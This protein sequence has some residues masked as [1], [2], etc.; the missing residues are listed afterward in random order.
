MLLYIPP[1]SIHRCD[2]IQA[3]IRLKY[4]TRMNQGPIQ[5]T[6]LKIFIKCATQ[7]YTARYAKILVAAQIEINGKDKKRPRLKGT[8]YFLHK[9]C[10][11]IDMLKNA[12]AINDIQFRVFER[13]RLAISAAEFDGTWGAFYNCRCSFDVSLS[14]DIVV[15]AYHGSAELGNLERKE[16]DSAADI[17][18]SHRMGGVFSKP[19]L[20]MKVRIRILP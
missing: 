15:R 9:G 13:K 1:Q 5:R 4:I 12:N 16:S 2:W 8:G 10:D 3:A 14:D 11:V 20:Y 17:C 7:F 18:N 6:R 19:V